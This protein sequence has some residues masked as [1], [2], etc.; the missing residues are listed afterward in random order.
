MP[1]PASGTYDLRTEQ[2][3][4][5]LDL[6]RWNIGPTVDRPLAARI[7]AMFTGAGSLN[8]PH[9]MGSLRV[10]NLSWDGTSPGTLD[11]DVQL[12]GQAAN[13][14]VR[15]PEIPRGV[16]LGITRA[17]LAPLLYFCNG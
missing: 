17:L 3:G 8:E 6:T 10:T 9:G 12:D 7:D 1:T 2:Y 16:P 5:T 11:A 4:A 15:A 14:D 13:V